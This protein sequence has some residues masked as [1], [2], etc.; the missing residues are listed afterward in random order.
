MSQVKRSKFDIRDYKIKVGS[1]EFPETFELQKIPVKNQG[2][3]PTCTAHAAASLVERHNLKETGKY[4]LFSTE[5]IYGAQLNTLTEGMSIREACEILKDYGDPKYEDC[6][7]NNKINKASKNVKD[8]FDELCKAA[9]PYRIKGYYRVKTPEEIKTALMTDGPVIFY[10]AT[11]KHATTLSGVYTYDPNAK[12]NGLHA[13]LIV[14]WDEI[15]WICQNSWGVTCGKGGYF[16][17]PYDYEICDAFGCIDM[18][19][20]MSNYIVKKKTKIRTFFYKAI[21]WFMNLVYNV[22]Y[23]EEDEDA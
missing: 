17:L 5:F 20:D 22:I 11:K 9:Y 7:G 13:M 1:V 19:N 14:G 21:N 10:F 4:E 18:E 2:L 12:S 6:P 15:G 3:S 8:N 23:N 16:T